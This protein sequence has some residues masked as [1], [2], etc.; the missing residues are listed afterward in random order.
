[1]INRLPS[2]VISNKNPYEF[3]HG[4]KPNISYLR[5][6]GCVCYVHVNENK[7]TKLDPRSR[8]CVFLGY[9]NGTKG[10]I[11]FDIKRRE[12]AISQNII[13]NETKFVNFNV[14][15]AK[16]IDEQVQEEGYN[17]FFDVPSS[18]QSETNEDNHEVIEDNFDEVHE[19][20]HQSSEGSVNESQEPRRSSRQRKTPAFLNDYHHQIYKASCNKNN[21][22]KYPMN[23]FI[24]YQNL[25]LKHLRFTLS[26]S[27]NSKPK[28][29]EEVVL[30]PEWNEVMQ[31]EIKARETNNTWI[32]IDLPP[33]KKSIGC[34]WVFKIKYK[35][36]GDIERHKAR[37][38]AKGFTQREVID[39]LEKY[40]PVAKLTCVRLL[41]ALTATKGWHIEQIDVNNAFLHSELEEEVYMMLPQGL[42]S[43]KPNQVCQLTKSLCGLK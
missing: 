13:F 7:C 32:I 14:S 37:L 3:L 19:D 30:F 15:T 2:P 38:M 27:S 1:M 35:A 16:D 34:K 42:T 26:I 10:Y 36:N 6:F 41:L 24:S 9:K 25:S 11:V 22:V 17:V 29:Y 18:D 40:S 8:K 31:A 39:Y 28:N 20:N 21:K 5:I 43:T 12:I 4:T 23:F 33:D